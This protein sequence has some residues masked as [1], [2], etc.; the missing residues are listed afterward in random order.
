M[1]EALNVE[2]KGFKVVILDEKDVRT[3]A[4]TEKTEGDTGN[5]RVTN[6]R[7]TRYA[8]PKKC[9]RCDECTGCCPVDVLNECDRNLS[10]SNLLTVPQFLYDIV[11]VE[12]R[13]MEKDGDE[14]W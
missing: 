3:C 4:D 5:V 12:D 8:T 1:Q 6:W 2:D 11:D 10:T 7:Q 9:I 14:K 13:S